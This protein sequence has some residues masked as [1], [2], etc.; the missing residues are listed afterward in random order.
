MIFNRSF[1]QN[2]SQPANIKRQMIGITPSNEHRIISGVAIG[3]TAHPWSTWQD[4]S[5]VKVNGL[6]MEVG[7]MGIIG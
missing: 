3:L 1:A 7:P 6:N 2:N 5:Y 4:T